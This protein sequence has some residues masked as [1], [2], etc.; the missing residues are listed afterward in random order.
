PENY[1]EDFAKAGAGFISVHAETIDSD[2]I[3]NDI[4]KL[5]CKA[6]I[7]FNPDTEIDFDTV[8][9]S[10]FVLI[11]SV[12]PGFGGQKFIDDTLNKVREIRQKFP[13][14]DIQID[15]G[16]NGETVKKAIEVGANWIVS[17]SYFWGSADL[18]K[19]AQELKNI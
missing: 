16:I 13:Q 2:E 19:T 9:K 7:V 3:L 10:D 18:Q 11:M 14:K 4:K 12:Y 15:G 8:E 6:G 17:G 1:I 5:K